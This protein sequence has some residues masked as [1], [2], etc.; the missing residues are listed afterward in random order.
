MDTERIFFEN[1]YLLFAL[2]WFLFGFF[3]L[4]NMQ[5]V[6]IPPLNFQGQGIKRAKLYKK[7]LVYSEQ[8]DIALN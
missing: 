1:I 6:Q 8:Y 7:V 3:G 5:H 2:V 4:L